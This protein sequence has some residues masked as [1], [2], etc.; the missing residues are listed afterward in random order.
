[1]K[2]TALIAAL[3]MTA[4]SL[5]LAQG[6]QPYIPRLPS[7]PM[8]GT[9]VYRPPVFQQPDTSWADRMQ[10]EREA[11]RQADIQ[12]QLEAQRI[13]EQR[14]MDSE[15]RDNMFKSSA[16]LLFEEEE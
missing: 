4:P 8:N 1:M 9:P 3:L 15:R 16:P 13:Q 10:A 12:R 2:T 11:S 5:A 14:Q 7:S 6:V